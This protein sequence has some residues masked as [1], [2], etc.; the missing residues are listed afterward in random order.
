VGELLAA[1]PAAVFTV[2]APECSGRRVHQQFRVRE[3]PGVV[4]CLFE[5]ALD[6]LGPLTG[7][8]LYLL[9]F[10][11]VRPGVVDVL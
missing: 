8:V 11:R 2:C 1:A 7:T 9:A 10:S 5:V 3:F 4:G 6:G